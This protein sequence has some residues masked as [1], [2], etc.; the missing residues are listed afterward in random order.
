MFPELQKKFVILYTVST[1]LIMTFVLSVAFL[2][3]A[4]S[5]ENRQKSTFQEHLFT[6]TTQLQVNSCFEDA[7]LAQMEQKNRLIIYIEENGTPFF[8]PGA[9]KTLTDR[10]ILLK[11]AKKAAQKESIYM[12]SHPISSDLLQSS[13][14]Q[15]TGDKKDSYLG[16][17]LILRTVSGY[18]K[19]I[20]L[21]DITD[22]HKK[23]LETGC[24]Y[25][26]ID[27]FGILFLFLSGRR[28]V[29]VSLKPLEET[30][31]KQ[32]DF[33]ASAS[34]ELRSP[35]AVIQAT[36]DALTAR[37]QEYDR[38]LSV[39]KSECRRGSALIKNL[40]LLVSA[41][42]KEWAVKKRI[43][44]IDELLLNLLEL[45]EPLCLSKGGRLLLELPDE[46]LPPVSADPDLC[47][48]ILTILL[49]NAV[50]YAL[51]DDTCSYVSSDEFHASLPVSSKACAD[52]NIPVDGSHLHKQTDSKAASDIGQRRSKIMLC[53]EYFQGHVIVSV[54]DHG[55]GISDNEKL[56]I[57]DRF[58]RNDKS[59]SNKEH[60]GLGLSIAATLA[61]I[62][63][64]RLT[65]E[66]TEG[67]GSTF[68]VKI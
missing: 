25:L 11:A 9:Y 4:S 14:F 5:Q 26:L 35:L 45:Y 56:L 22:A 61:K 30:C 42:Q 1:G 27:L 44:E 59:R 41:E 53:A 57:F 12:D 39:I 36:A 18:K 33:V 10:E 21:L 55:P 32:Q 15:I 24:T 46:P 52:K 60:F 20:L 31:Q 62:Q 54:I 68:S 29:R 17:V 6:L 28:F 50:S 13:V 40:L 7:F 3:Y 37:P 47:R 64:L 38:C 43:F 63:G 34:H 51:S 16:N 48:Q 67:G 2:F 23:I 49:D 66:D 8:F 65:V 58:Y 19:M